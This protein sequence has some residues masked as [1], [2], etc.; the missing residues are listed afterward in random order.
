[1]LPA[2]LLFILAAIF[3]LAAV[4]IPAAVFIEDI[5]SSNN[6]IRKKNPGYSI[7]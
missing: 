4:F 7:K 2:V 5:F 6:N 3:I 1:M